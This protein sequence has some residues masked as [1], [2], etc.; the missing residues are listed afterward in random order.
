MKCP[1]RCWFV[2]AAVGVASVATIAWT[3]GKGIQLG[4][5]I[6]RLRQTRRRERLPFPRMRERLPSPM[7][8]ETLLPMHGASPPQEPGEFA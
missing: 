5:L 6:A 4:V 8:V 1:R 7:V 3:I 2:S